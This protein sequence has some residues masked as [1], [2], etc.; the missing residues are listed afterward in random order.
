MIDHYNLFTKIAYVEL[1]SP[2][3]SCATFFI[4]TTKEE[5]EREK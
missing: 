2:T 1:Q 4:N 3:G 5:E